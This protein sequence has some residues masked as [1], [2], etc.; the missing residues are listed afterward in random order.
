LDIHPL[1]HQDYYPLWISEA[2]NYKNEALGIRGAVEMS[3]HVSKDRYD[4]KVLDIQD[5]SF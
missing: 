4:E 1:R 3:K 2:T 5:Q